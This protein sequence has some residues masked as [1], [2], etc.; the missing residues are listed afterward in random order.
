MAETAKDR[1]RFA[2]QQCDQLLSV[3]ASR[4][5]QTVNCPKC[6]R[7]NV[8]PNAEVAALQLAERRKRRDK[9]KQEGA[10]DASQ[11]EVY[12]DETEF[13]FET[14]ED[15]EGYYGGRVDRSKV[16]VPRVVLYTQG[17]L[18]GV[19]AIGAFLLG[20]LLGITTSGPAQPNVVDSTP[21][22]VKGTLTFVDGQNRQRPDAGSVVILVPQDAPPGVDEKVDV[23]GLGPDEP[24]PEPSTHPG[25][26]RI[27]VMG[28]AYARTD[29]EG[30]YRL[31]VPQRGRYFMLVISGNSSRSG[32]ERLNHDHLAEMGRYFVPALD[33]IGDREFRWSEKEIGRD[34]TVDLSFDRS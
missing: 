5:G 12:D 8:V 23:A 3:T 28:G 13:I 25:L 18:L 16:A 32:G 15:E 29:A 2:C 33:L 26:Q 6:E 7:A 20:W 9:K 22:V 21:R 24:L 4:Q 14:D 30:A 27:S 17:A 1:L 10:G 34:M 19:V 11:F 31:Q